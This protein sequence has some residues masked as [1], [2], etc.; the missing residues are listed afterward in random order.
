M[1]QL[2][3]LFPQARKPLPPPTEETAVQPLIIELTGALAE[4]IRLDAGMVCKSPEQ[5]V[6]DWLQ[7]GFPKGAA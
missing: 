2:I 3:Q 4:A 5:F 6:R 1:G 7:S